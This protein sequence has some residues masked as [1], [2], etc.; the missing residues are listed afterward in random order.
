MYR[1]TGLQGSWC[2]ALKYESQGKMTNLLLNHRS[3]EKCVFKKKKHRKTSHCTLKTT[4][5]WIKLWLDFVLNVQTDKTK[6]QK[7]G[8][9]LYIHWYSIFPKIEEDSFAQRGVCAL[10]GWILTK[11]FPYNY[12]D[13]D[14]FSLF[15]SCK[16]AH[17]KGLVFCSYG[18]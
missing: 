15:S 16:N 13:G 9:M 6:T 4:R 3:K 10:P 12:K 17:L 18:S 14:S 8:Y 1:Y 2:I 7:Y 5:F 11:L